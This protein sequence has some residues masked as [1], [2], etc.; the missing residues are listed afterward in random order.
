MK[1]RFTIVILVF[2]ATVALA[3]P[4]ANVLISWT[5]NTEADLSGYHVYWNGAQVGTIMAPASSWIGIVN[6]IEGTNVAQVSAFDKCTPPNESGKS[7]VTPASTLIFDSTPPSVP[8]GCIV[9]PQ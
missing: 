5:P 2:L 1:R 3:A 4:T 7:V 6:M 9:Q 8:A